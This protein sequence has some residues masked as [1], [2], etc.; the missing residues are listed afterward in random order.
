MSFSTLFLGARSN[1]VG[2]LSDLHHVS[3]Y[4]IMNATK[5]RSNKAFMLW[6]EARLDKRNRN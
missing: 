1:S 6:L 5:L 3:D 2:G 4:D